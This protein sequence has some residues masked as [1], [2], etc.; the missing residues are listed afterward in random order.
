MAKPKDHIRL[1]EFDLK[2]KAN[3]FRFLFGVD[4]AGRGPL[5]G[6]VV[7]AAVCLRETL[8]K[9]RIDD[10]KLLSSQQRRK[11]FDEIFEHAWVGIGFMSEAVIDEVNILRA[12]HLAMTAAVKDLVAHLPGELTKADKFIGSVKVVVDGNSYRGNIPFLTQTVIQGDGKSL[13]I[14]CAS[15]VAKVYRDSLMEKFDRVYPGYGFSRHKGYPTAAHRDAVKRL[16]HSPIHRR[17]FTVK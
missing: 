10:S 13:S 6:P 14:A 17:T 7:A 4:E 12:S 15:I 2:A 1:I 9:N 8:F 5:A 3:S 16:G 11:A